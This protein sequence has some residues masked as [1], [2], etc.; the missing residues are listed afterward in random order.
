M[1]RI[2]EKAG[3]PALVHGPSPLALAGIGGEGRFSGYASVFDRPDLGRDVIARGAFSRSLTERGS[4]GVR[5]L[6]Q[7]DPAEVIGR[8]TVIREDG[9]GLYVEGQLT[10]GAPRA[11]EV[12]ANLVNRAIDGLS[13][14]FRAVRSRRDEKRGY[15][16]ILEADLWEI[17]IVT[18][19]MLPE[20]RVGAVKRAPPPGIALSRTPLSTR[21]DLNR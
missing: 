7:H 2:L 9:H 16:R 4:G 20:A 1:R 8:W 21:G 5:M 14:G 15:R 12:Y 10:P 19:P 18:F 3:R 6:Y 11:A 17:S 13:I